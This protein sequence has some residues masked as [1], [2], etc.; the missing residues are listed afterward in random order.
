MTTDDPSGKTPQHFLD[1]ASVMRLADEAHAYIR[2]H[3]AEAISLSSAI[4][5][6][7]AALRLTIAERSIDEMQALLTAGWSLAALL[8]SGGAA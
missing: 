3:A 1:L 7:D 5:D 8:E 2:H 6:L 4:S